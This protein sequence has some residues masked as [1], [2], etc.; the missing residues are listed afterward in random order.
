MKDD[1]KIIETQDGSKT[2]Y[3]A[4]RDVPYRTKRGAQTESRF[5][6]V[7][8]SG[9]TEKPAPWRVL[10]LGFGA[11]VNFVQT[12]LACLEHDDARL[13]YHSVDCAPV[14]PELLAFHL[15]EVGELARQALQHVQNRKEVG[16]SDDLVQVSGFDGRIVLNLYPK[17]WLEFDEPALSAEAVYFDPFGPRTEPDSWTNE[18]F[19]VAARHLSDTGVLATY[20]AATHVK[21]AIFKAGLWAATANGP[22]RKR[23]IT[24]A[25]KHAETL[26]AREGFELLSRDRYVRG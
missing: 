9:I 17:A 15:G 2:L 25:A 7:D 3:D 1:I 10:E 16:E 14:A 24:F 23:E 11:G 4:S 19:E 18:C 5:I 8:G 22:G 20:S 13:E 6:F 26:E 21:R 12:A